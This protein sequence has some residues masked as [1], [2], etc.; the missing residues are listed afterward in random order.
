MQPIPKNC[1][2]QNEITANMQITLGLL[3][4]LCGQTN[5]VKDFEVLVEE[6][7]SFGVVCYKDFV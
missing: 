7:L 1:N 4:N 6:C 5:F 3:S 2:Y